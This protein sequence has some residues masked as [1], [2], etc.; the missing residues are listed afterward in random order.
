[1][2]ILLNKVGREGGIKLTDIEQTL[3]G[4]PVWE[5]LPS[6][7]N[8]VVPS[9]NQGGI[10]LVMTHP[11]SRIG[12]GL[13]TLKDKVEGE[14]VFGPVSKKRVLPAKLALGGE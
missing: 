8:V 3:G 1:M 6:E 5:S 2:R 7:E 11:N 14:K 13:R 10:P 12:Q 4:M 9:I